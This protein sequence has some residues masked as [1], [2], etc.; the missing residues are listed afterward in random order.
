M[1][2][3]APIGFPRENFRRVPHASG[4][5]QANACIMQL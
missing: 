5:E 3:M 4:V 1:I 2:D